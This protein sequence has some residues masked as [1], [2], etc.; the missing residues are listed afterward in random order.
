MRGQRGVIETHWDPVRLGAALARDKGIKVKTVRA[1]FQTNHLLKP[2]LSAWNEY[3]DEYF[4]E[5]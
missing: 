5:E 1:R 2:Y 3:E 4:P